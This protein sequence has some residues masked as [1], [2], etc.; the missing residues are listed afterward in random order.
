MDMIQEVIATRPVLARDIMTADAVTLTED[1][2]LFA[3]AEELIRHRVSNAPVIEK[4]FTRQILVGFVSEKDLMQAY[5]NGWFYK[6]PDMK[7]RDVMRGN[8]ICVKPETDLF[9][10]A[11]IFMQHGFRHVPVVSAHMLL[12]MVSRRDVLKALI[13]HYRDWQELP[14]SERKMP[15]LAGIFTPHYL[16]G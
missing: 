8:P 9:A 7:V 13:G 15:D 12:G 10:L 1:T 4:D 16:L 6:H 2:G 3:A 11:A 5:A 14:V